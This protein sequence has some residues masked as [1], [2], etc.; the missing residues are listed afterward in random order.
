MSGLV[1]ILMAGGSGTR[2]WPA[3][4]AARPKQFLPIGGGEPLLQRTSSRL[5]GV[6]PPER[7]LVITS[8]RT[9]DAVREL[10][11]ELPAENVVGEPE[12]RDTAPCVGLACELAAR[13]DEDCVALA[14]PSDHVIGPV[15]SFVERLRAA[16]AALTAHPESILVFGIEPDRP[17]T[18]YGY[19]RQGARVGAYGGHDVFALDAFVEKP[20]LEKAEAMLAAGG[21]LWNAGLFAFRPSAMRAA[22]RAHLSDMV[23]PLTALAD[24]WRTPGFESAMAA[25]FGALQKIS[26]DFGVMEHVTDTLMLPLPL[27]WDDVGSWS[28]LERLRDADADGNVIDGDAV[29]QETR[30]CIVSSTDG[31]LV[32]VQGVDNLIVVHTPD[33]TLVCRR[34]DDQGVKRIVEELKARGLEGFL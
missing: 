17:A 6:V 26:I 33:A 10:L 7:R 18:G 22:Y 8:A 20:A 28:A 32:A 3:S 11:P 14:M 9:V 30:D 27:R 21:H 16:E 29:L 13:I 4:R 1:A 31:S 12:G 24:A 15:A 19:L 34:D 5:D 25:G 23:A 2:F